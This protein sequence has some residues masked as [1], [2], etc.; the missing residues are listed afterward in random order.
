[1]NNG[2]TDGGRS[3]RRYLGLISDAEVISLANHVDFL[4]TPQTILATLQLPNVNTKIGINAVRCGYVA[5]LLLILNFAGSF[6]VGQKP[7]IF[8][9]NSEVAEGERQPTMMLKGFAY[10]RA[11]VHRVYSHSGQSFRQNQH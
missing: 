6:I 2:R 10:A 9:L 5:N 11:S 4:A 3:A 1:M 8:R 7:I